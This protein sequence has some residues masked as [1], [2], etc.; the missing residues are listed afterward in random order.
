M[1][2]ADE[3]IWHYKRIKRDLESAKAVVTKTECWNHASVLYSFVFDDKTYRGASSFTKRPCGSYGPGDPIEVYFSK[4]SPDNNSAME[5]T[6]GIWNEII[7]ITLASLTFPAL[8]LFGLRKY[9]R[10][11]NKT[12]SG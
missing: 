4:I 2:Y 9:W 12:A 10:D 5:P 8:L 7:A 6:A 11:L 3:N 1:I